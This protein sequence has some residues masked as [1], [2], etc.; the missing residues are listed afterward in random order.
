MI[1]VTNS[2]I[3]SQMNIYKFLVIQAEVN[4]DVS[5]LNVTVLVQFNMNCLVDCQEQEVEKLKNTTGSILEPIVIMYNGEIHFYNV[6]LTG[7]LGF[8]WIFL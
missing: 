6:S 2:I 3:Q 5:I 4:M 8:S 1:K 7:K